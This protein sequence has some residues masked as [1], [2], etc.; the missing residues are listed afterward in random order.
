MT[1]QPKVT[2]GTTA[3]T[4]NTPKAAATSSPGACP[5]AEPR[6]V[7]YAGPSGRATPLGRAPGLALKPSASYRAW[8]SGEKYTCPTS[9]SMRRARRRAPSRTSSLAAGVGMAG[10]PGSSAW[11]GTLL[12]VASPDRAPV[13]DLLL[14]GVAVVAVSTSAPLI[15]GADAPALAIA[16]WRNALSLPILAAWLLARRAERAGWRARSAA[17]RRRS[18]LAGAFLAAHFATW[19]PSLSFTSRWR[20]RCARAP[21]NPCG[22]PSSLADR[23]G[24][25]IRPRHLGGH[26]ARDGGRLPPHGGGPLHLLRALFGD[27]LAL[28]GGMLAA[29]YVTV[30]A[31]VRRHVSTGGLC[32][33]LLRHRRGPAARPVCG[34]GTG[35]ER[36][37]P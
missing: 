22:L 6:L 14:L 11:R 3:S 27:L 19:I 35:A 29:A 31:D 2:A 28:L 5:R 26:R 30:G 34:H 24:E 13:G 21:P 18:R 7:K 17:D 9:G 4:L 15:A 16:F 36:V 25:Q 8:H 20:R 32:A 33:G 10:P 1:P 23:G 12:L 37:R